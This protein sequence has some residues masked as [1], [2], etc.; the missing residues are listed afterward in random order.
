MCFQNLCICPD[1]YF[2]NLSTQS[3]DV[4]FPEHTECSKACF[5]PRTCVNNICI[6]PDNVDCSLHSLQSEIRSKRQTEGCKQNPD[7]CKSRNSICFHDIC[8]C[9]PDFREKNGI[10]VP[11]SYNSMTRSSTCS[12]QAL[13]PIHFICENEKCRCESEEFN[14]VSLLYYM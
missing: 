13:C 4:I 10:C 14:I 3:C 8:Q 1:R 5:Y 2:H 12:S 9:A 7:I 11:K 6:C